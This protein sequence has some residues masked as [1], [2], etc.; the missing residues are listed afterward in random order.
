M[1][2]TNQPP[3]TPKSNERDAASGSVLQERPIS[4]CWKYD[5]WSTVDFDCLTEDSATLN[6][7][8]REFDNAIG[9]GGGGFTPAELAEFQDRL[10]AM[11]GRI[12]RIRNSYY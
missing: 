9:A 5:G 2:S 8:A 1:H 12:K 3:T 4:R 10:E 6:A 7:L 11:V